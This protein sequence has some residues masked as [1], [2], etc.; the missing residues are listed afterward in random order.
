MDFSLNPPIG[1]TLP[2]KVISPVIAISLLIFLLRS[3]LSIE[4]VSVIPA[5]GPFLGIAVLTALMCIVFPSNLDKS[6][7]NSSL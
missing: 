5:E 4:V 3:K 2:F 6:T 7:F 1:N